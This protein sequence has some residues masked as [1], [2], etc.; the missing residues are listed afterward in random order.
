M[1][2][3]VS[4]IVPCYNV[5]AYIDV[6]L[7]SL[8]RQTLRSI[9][10]ICIND[11]STDNTWNCLL[12]WQ[13]KDDR[14]ILLNQSNAGVSTARNAGLDA[15]R[16]L[17]V[18]FADPDDYAD[19]EMY[20]RLLSGALEHDADVVECGNHVFSDTTAELI[21]SRR[22]SPAWTLNRMRLPPTSSGIPSGERWISAYG[23]SCSGEACWKRTA[24]GSTPI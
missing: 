16:G 2:P 23:A 6:C 17:Y 18:G 24:S 19:P 21:V 20:G 1:P 3:D 8:T 15:A 11:G 12:R 10:I 4:I 7:E 9:E 5:A 22:R 13:A 14:I